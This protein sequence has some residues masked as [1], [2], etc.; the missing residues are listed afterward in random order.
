MIVD[1]DPVKFSGQS[2]KET[3]L[4]PSFA[5]K[6]VQWDSLINR[7]GHWLIPL[8]LRQ[9]A[10]L[11]NPTRNKIKAIAQLKRDFYDNTIKDEYLVWHEEF[12]LFQEV[13]L[14]KVRFL[15]GERTKVSDK[16]NQQ[17]MVGMFDVAESKL[18]VSQRKNL[19]N[20]V[21]N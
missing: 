8:D 6:I 15:K 3:P 4:L 21:R 19:K 13:M 10:E 2:A 5:F 18:T 17:D 9:T 20:N 16:L 7:I 11:K 1:V 14:N 12:L